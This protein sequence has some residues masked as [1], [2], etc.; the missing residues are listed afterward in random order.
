M[1]FY[2]KIFCLNLFIENDLGGIKLPIIGPKG[3]QGPPGPIGLKGS[4]G[5][6]GLNGIPAREL[7]LHN[8]S[9]FFATLI[10]NTGPY[11]QDK[12]IVFSNVL[13]NYGKN[14]DPE[15]GIYTAP[16]TGTYQ[17]SITISATGRQKVFIFYNIILIELMKKNLIFK[18]PV[19][20]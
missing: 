1:W 6:Q 14:Y 15:T 12:D 8:F 13:T 17:F 7:P 18:R 16:F 20:L 10:N 11:T 2:N 19:Y 5:E 3:D 4:K 9:A